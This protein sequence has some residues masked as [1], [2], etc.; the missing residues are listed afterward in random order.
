MLARKQWKVRQEHR[1]EARGEGRGTA[2]FVGWERWEQH[3]LAVETLESIDA[4]LSQN[5]KGRP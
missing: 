1:L 4:F 3:V 2:S 5:V